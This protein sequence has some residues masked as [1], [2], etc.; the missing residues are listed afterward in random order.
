VSLRGDANDYIS[1]KFLK[2]QNFV[3]AHFTK[4]TPMEICFHNMG[5]YFKAKKGMYFKAKKGKHRAAN[6]FQQRAISLSFPQH[7]S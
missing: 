1:G 4:V 2:I 3:T 6:H 5:M 7:P